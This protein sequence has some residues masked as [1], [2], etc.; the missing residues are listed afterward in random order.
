MESIQFQNRLTGAL[1]TEKVYGESFLR[2]AYGN[3]L[4]PIAL[5]AFIKRP[6]FSSW[7]GRRMSTAESRSRIAPFIAEYG[8]DPADFADSPES[9]GS[10]NEFFY[11]KLKPEARPIDPDANSIVFPADGRHLGFQKASEIEGVFVKGQKWDL[12]ALL[13][14]AD[15]AAKYA[16]GS[17]VLSRLCPVD[18]HRF[19]FPAAG[20]PGETVLLNGPLFSVSPIALRKNLGYMWENKRTLTRLETPNVG[21]V[22]CLEIGATCVGTIIQ[23]F[24]P[25]SPVEKGAEKG[26]FAFGGSSTITLFEPGAVLLENDLR[27]HS[28]KQ[29]ELYSLVGSRMGYVA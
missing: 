23:T 22:L 7:Y 19:H 10:F 4:G 20:V 14:D 8:L 1:E 25:G 26:Y 2:W 11:R 6:F 29:T 28:S 15:L 18:Y 3:P 9:Y 17:L 16:N 5:N 24:D 27:H 13:G 12:A 21:T